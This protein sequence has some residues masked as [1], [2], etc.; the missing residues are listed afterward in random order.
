MGCFGLTTP[1]PSTHPSKRSLIDKPTTTTSKR[2][3][4][5]PHW[6]Y[7]WPWSEWCLAIHRFLWRPWYRHR[8]SSWL[9]LRHLSHQFNLPWICIGD[10][11]EIL[12]ADEKQGWLCRPERQMHGFRD[13]LDYC[14]LR[15]LGFSSYPFTWCNKTLG[16]QNV[17]ILL[18]RRVASVEWILR[19]PSSWVHHLDAFHSW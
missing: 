18:D 2:A 12:F 13:A 9:L 6:C 3:T 1:I 17:W 14:N 19:F 16:N 11:N 8:Q 4:C 5:S 7:Y 15:D 10:F